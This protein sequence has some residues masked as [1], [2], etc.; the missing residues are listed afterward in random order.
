VVLENQEL[1]VQK[2]YFDQLKC[3]NNKKMNENTDKLPRILF[4]GSRGGQKKREEGKFF[5]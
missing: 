4:W 1:L 3:N 5:L 2:Q